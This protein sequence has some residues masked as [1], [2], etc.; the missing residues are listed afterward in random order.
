M[1]GQAADNF[2]ICTAP[3][4]DSYVL[5]RARIGGGTNVANVYTT[6]RVAG[7]IAF[8]AHAHSA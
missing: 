2:L 7:V 8:R 1:C 6:P 5:G 3:Q 4:R